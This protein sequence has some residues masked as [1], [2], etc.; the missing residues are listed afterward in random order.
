MRNPLKKHLG[1]VPNNCIILVPF[2]LLTFIACQSEDNQDNQ[3]NQDYFIEWDKSTLVRV[4]DEGGYPR[5]R[6]LNDHSLI[7][8]YENWRG[9]VM[10]KKSTDEGITWGAPVMAYEAFD[11][12]DDQTGGTTRVNIA[13]PEIIQLNN[14]DL[15]LAANLRPRN[16]RNACGCA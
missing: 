11:Y 13:N 7:V 6:R 3:D 8:A 2:L 15:L 9:D 10:V 4:A 16:E 5:M 12:T 14:G 1:V